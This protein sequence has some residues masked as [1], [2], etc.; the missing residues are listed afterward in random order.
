VYKLDLGTHNVTIQIADG[1]YTAAALI[2]G[3]IANTGRLTI[4]GNA[5]TPANVLINLSSADGFY[6]IDSN[7]TPVTIKNLKI[8]TAT[9]G[10]ALR[11]FNG[12]MYFQNIDFGA[13]AGYQIYASSNG[14][15]ESTGNFSVSGGALALAYATNNSV[16]NIA[17]RTITFSNNPAYSSYAVGARSLATVVING[18]TFTNGNTVTGT[19]YYVDKNALIDTDGGGANY[20]PGDGAGSAATGGT[21]I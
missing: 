6:V 5:G 18:M 4:Q 2:R 10:S 8:T 1:T 9:S 17:A 12:R 16:V 11:A 13:V 21:Y 3:Y 19:R 20:I 14:Y 15:I 7:D